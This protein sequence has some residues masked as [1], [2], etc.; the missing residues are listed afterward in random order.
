MSRHWTPEEIQS[1]R[2]ELRKLLPPGS[3]AYTVLRHVASSG[4]T[5]W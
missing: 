1:A 3:T 5:R 4:M 2:A